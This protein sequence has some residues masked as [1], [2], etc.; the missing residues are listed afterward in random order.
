MLGA[1][2]GVV[3][4]MVVLG[5]PLGLLW[6]ALAPSVA[7]LK[8]ADGAVA[9]QPE[10]EEFI[11]ADGWFTLLGLGFGIILAVLAWTLLRRLRGPVT[12]LALA[13]GGIGAAVLAWRLGR[14]IGL[15]GFRRLVESAPTGQTF[16]KPPDLRAGGVDWWAGVLPVPHGDLL[17]PALAAVITYT[18]L[19]GWSRWP[20]LQPEPEP[21]PP[22][23]GQRPEPDPRP[24]PDRWH[25]YAGPEQDQPP[26]SDQSPE[27][28]RREP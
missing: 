27:P 10:P 3:I 2:A 15:A 24:E 17:A 4:V 14:S 5:A 13:L 11:A 8:T 7:V 21:G 9:A 6:R 28:D 18:L 23:P 25:P 1:A 16:S 22:E 20:S 26:T 12:L 19:S